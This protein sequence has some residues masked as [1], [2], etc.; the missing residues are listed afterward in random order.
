MVRFYRDP[1]AA[2]L[3]AAGFAVGAFMFHLGWWA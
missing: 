1:S 3:V 2:W